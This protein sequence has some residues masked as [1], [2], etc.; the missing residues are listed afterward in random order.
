MEN[1][2]GEITFDGVYERVN[3]PQGYR[4]TLFSLSQ[5]R[6][7]GESSETGAG[8][9]YQKEVKCKTREIFLIK[10]RHCSMGN[11]HLLPL[12]FEKFHLRP[13]IWENG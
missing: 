11:D 13:L 4:G 9:R 2:R 7:A 3:S 8:G 10:I 6:L 12:L 5:C 1:W